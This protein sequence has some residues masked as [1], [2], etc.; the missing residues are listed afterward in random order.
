MTA[1]VDEREWEVGGLG[2]SVSF[3]S[4]GATLR[5]YGSVDGERKELLRFDDFVDNPH[6]HVPAEN[7]P[8]SF[9]RAT[10]GEPLDWFVTQIRDHLGDL[11]TEAGFAEVRDRVDLGAVAADAERVRQAMVDCVPQGYVRVEG[12]GLQRAGQPAVE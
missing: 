9:D 7:H 11:L 8:I 10:L 3:R 5:V 6:Y 2:F 12:V 4:P 1:V